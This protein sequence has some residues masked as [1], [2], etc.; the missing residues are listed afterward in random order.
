MELGKSGS[1]LKSVTHSQPEHKFFL[2]VNTKQQFAKMMEFLPVCCQ[3]AEHPTRLSGL[4]GHFR[5]YLLS[6]WVML[7][8]RLPC[9][10]GSTEASRQKLQSLSLISCIG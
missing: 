4:R 8:F 10:S 5:S 7:R 6:E 9:F 3:T 1:A 2:Y